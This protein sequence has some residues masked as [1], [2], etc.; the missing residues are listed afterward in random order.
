MARTA[1][2]RTSCAG[3]GASR[4]GGYIHAPSIAH[5]ATAGLLRS[6]YLTHN[7][8][9]DGNG[10]FAVDLSSTRVRVA[11][12]LLEGLRQGQSLAALLGYRIERALARI[13]VRPAG[14]V[15]AGARAARGRTA[16]HA[17]TKI[18][19]QPAA[20]TVAAANVVDGLA[21]LTM[22]QNSPDSV[23]KPLDLPP[24]NNPFIA[25]LWTPLSP[26]EKNGV[27]SAILG[28]VAA[29]DAYADVVLAEGVHQLVQGNTG[30]AA[31]ALDAGGAGEAPPIEPT[32]VETPAQGIPFTHRLMILAVGSAPAW[33]TERPRAKAEPRLERW[34]A[35]RLGDRR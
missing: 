27:T 1:G 35:T 21:L 25:G 15:A 20:E 19:P 17:W 18:V 33:S 11:L 28:A 6:A 10:A 16:H 5:A 3:G 13:P 29:Y 7:P 22:F 4:D 32:V 9:G 2:W 31:A 26:A 12:D 30:R 34:A 24:A 8:T 23:L 14:A